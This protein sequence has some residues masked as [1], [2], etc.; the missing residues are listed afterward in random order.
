MDLQGVHRKSH[1]GS[2]Q[3]KDPG[4]YSTLIVHNSSLYYRI[5]EWNM[6]AFNTLETKMLH[7]GPPNW[8]AKE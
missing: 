4:R 8:R 5:F 2:G 7:S 3:S 6:E 1:R